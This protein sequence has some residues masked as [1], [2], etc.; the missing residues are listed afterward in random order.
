MDLGHDLAVLKQM[1]EELPE[2]LLAEPVFWQMQAPSNYPKLSLGQLLL[3]RAR[4]QGAGEQ[5]DASQRAERDRIERD[6]E[7]TL[8]RWPVAAEKKAE[9][10]LRSRV[11]LWQRYWDDCREDPR[12]CA[13]QY[14]NEVTQRTIAELLLRE[15]PRI[16]DSVEARPRR[17]MD[18][19]VRARLQGDRFVWQPDLQ[20]SFPE[21][22]FWFL[23]GQPHYNRQS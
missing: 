10:E 14:A 3:K 19:L 2:Y 22:Q 21:A 23:Y 4:L 11:N 6:I 13:D 5:L 8:G 15:F 9:Q 16:A 18:A 12:S 7:T 20:D 17:A 1:V